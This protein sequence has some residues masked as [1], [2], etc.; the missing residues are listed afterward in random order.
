MHIKHPNHRSQTTTRGGINLLLREAKKLHRAATSES[1]SQALPVLRRLIASNTL[2]GISLPDLRRRQNIVQR[3]HILHMLAIEAGYSSWEEYRRIIAN[4]SADEIEH[5]DIV[6]R[7]AGYPNI[8]F[9]SFAEAREFAAL[10]GGH[11]LRVG[12]QAVV[13]AEVQDNFKN[14]DIDRK[15]T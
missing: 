13:F 10:Y 7:K 15:G 5:F 9:S 4:V 6:H 12:Q 8:W 1:L 3:K 11:P 2:K 14:L